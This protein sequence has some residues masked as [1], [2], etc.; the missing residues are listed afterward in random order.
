MPEEIVLNGIKDDVTCAMKLIDAGDKGRSVAA[1]EDIAEG[2][3]VAEYKYESDFPLKERPAKER[4]YALNGEGCFILE[5]QIPG[6]SWVCLDATRNVDCWARYIN[7]GPPKVANLKMFRPVTMDKRWHVCFLAKRPIR[8]G[9]ELLYDYGKQPNAPPWL[10]RKKPK[11]QDTKSKSTDYSGLPPWKDQA[12][13]QPPV[14]PPS[15]HELE[16]Q[17]PSPLLE[18]ET[19]L[20]H[21]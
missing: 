15:T 8:A 21:R 19:S 16:D 14:Q 6:G 10:A 18:N 20:Q 2:S 13:V 1:D 9:E 4:E 3:F 12:S 7:H 5:A 17:N 11:A